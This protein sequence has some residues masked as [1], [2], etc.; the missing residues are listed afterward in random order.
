MIHLEVRKQIIA[1]WER[2]VT[3]NELVTSYGFCRASIYNLIAQYRD[4]GNIEPRLSTRGRKPKITD[5]HLR[6]IDEAIEARPDMTLSEII[7]DLDLPIS[8]SQLSRVIRGKLGYN[9][10]KRLST[11][12]NER[13]RT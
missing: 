12:R 5:D 10:K 11:Q 3:V 9:F 13:G 8:E 6:R 4:T 7:H 2:G 1:A